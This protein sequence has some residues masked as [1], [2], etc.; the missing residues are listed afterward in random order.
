MRALLMPVVQ[1]RT[2]RRSGRQGTMHPCQEPARGRGRTALA[3]AWAGLSGLWASLRCGCQGA[4]C[5]GCSGGR[6]APPSRGRCCG[7]GG[8][9]RGAGTGGGG[10]GCRACCK[11]GATGGAWQSTCYARLSVCISS[12][13]PLLARMIWV[14]RSRTTLPCM[15]AIKGWAALQKHLKKL[16]CMTCRA[17]YMTLAACGRCAAG[18]ACG[19]GSSRGCAPGCSCKEEGQERC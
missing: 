3:G 7:G 17:V 15:G 8:G 16:Y 9:G 1:G 13:A 2:D 6:R 14:A 12:A 11:G 5:T 10:G 18:T 4:G 19:R